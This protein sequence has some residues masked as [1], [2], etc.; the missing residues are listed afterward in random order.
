MK[1]QTDYYFETGTAHTVCR[2]Y[3]LN[4]CYKHIPYIILGDGCSSSAFTDVGA[5]ILVHAF[6]GALTETV[7]AGKLKEGKINGISENSSA[8]KE[9]VQLTTHR[10]KHAARVMQLPYSACDSTLLAAFIHKGTC[11]IF[12]SGDGTLVMKK[13]DSVEIVRREFGDNAPPYLSYQLE[14]KRQKRYRDA[15]GAQSVDSTT[16]C[17]DS[18]FTLQHK[19]TESTYLFD[20]NWL[21]VDASRLESVSLASDGIST[22][23]HLPDGENGGITH[24]GAP[25]FT[26]EQGTIKNPEAEPPGIIGMARLFTA[27]KNINGRFV[28]RRMKRLARDMEK[29][30]IGHYDDI[31]TAT[32]ILEGGSP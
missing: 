23:H 6:K 13:K 10:S 19:K 15:H 21:T 17:C 22:Y 18:L 12:F 24:K 20:Y 2:D 29:R 11:W 4:G 9:L 26:A 16:F 32:I 8:L 1:Y 27:Y 14:P 7:D 28:H 30:G 3:A 31:S 25:I 5:R